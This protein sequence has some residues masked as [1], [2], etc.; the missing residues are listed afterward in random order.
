MPFFPP[1]VVVAF[2]VVGREWTLLVVK[3][4]DLLHSRGAE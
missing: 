4:V 2:V 1:P 3:D